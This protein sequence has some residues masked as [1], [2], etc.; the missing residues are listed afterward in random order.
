M[1]FQKNVKP[2]VEIH[3]IRG[4]SPHGVPTYHYLAVYSDRVRDM[5][6]SLITK[7]TNLE[8]FGV[9]VASGEGE[10]DEETKAYIQKTFFS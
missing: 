9:I 6:L 10:P 4:E 5:K 3:L 1:M 7:T 8:D 2:K